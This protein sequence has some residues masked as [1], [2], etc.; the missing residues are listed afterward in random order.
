LTPRSFDPRKMKNILGH[1]IDFLL[2]KMRCTIYFNLIA[3][4]NAMNCAHNLQ[5]GK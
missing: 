3:E 1:L 4:Q 5:L 2:N